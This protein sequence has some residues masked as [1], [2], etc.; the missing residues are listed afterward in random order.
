M[1]DLY[2]GEGCGSLVADVGNIKEDLVR[3]C[4]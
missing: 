1:G 2:G 4:H 3:K